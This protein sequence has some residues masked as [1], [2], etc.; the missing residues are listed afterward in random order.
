M[1]P[2]CQDNRKLPHIMRHVLETLA[3][4]RCD[5]KCHWL[6][7]NMVRQGNKQGGMDEVGQHA[8]T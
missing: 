2:C 4:R 8:R 3:A 5:G 1:L 7:K 6:L